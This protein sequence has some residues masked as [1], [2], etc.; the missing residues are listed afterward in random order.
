M[1]S[2]GDGQS[3]LQR[4][5]VH[6]A[7]RA[8]AQRSVA[9]DRRTF[10][11]IV[12]LTNCARIWPV[13]A[14]VGL[15]V[16]EGLLV[17]KAGKSGSQFYQIFVDQDAARFRSTLATTTLQWSGVCLILTASYLFG[18]LL[19]IRWRRRI[20]AALHNRYF[21]DDAFFRMSAPVRSEE[22]ADTFFAPAST[23]EARCCAPTMPASPHG[24]APPSPPVQI[25]WH[26]AARWTDNPD[27]RMTEDV[28]LFCTALE[29]LFQQSAKSPFNLILFSYLTVQA[30][31]SITPVLVALVFFVACAALHR[32][33]VAAIAS[34][35]YTQARTEGDFR[36][37]HVR[38]RDNAASIAAWG[39][40][41]V[42][43]SE[44]Q[45]KLSTTL[46]AQTRLAWACSAQM[47]IKSVWPLPF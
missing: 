38:I 1:G 26:A 41:G 5:P 23:L 39:G 19:I 45:E 20:T 24:R 40:G 6:T 31:G 34:A 18:Q 3:L 15:A 33:V 30:F 13:L 46:W 11:D 42:E 29:K 25:P 9:A 21:H 36:S 47:L 7:L 37:G 28:A 4:E 35:V 32:L 27:Q 2:G 10:R 12:L 22:Q 14:L 8:G 16:L 17:S 44:L 43:H